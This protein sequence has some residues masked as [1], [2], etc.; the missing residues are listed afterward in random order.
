MVI[1]YQN[2]CLTYPGIVGVAGYGTEPPP[3]PTGSAL[4][5]SNN[6]LISASFN[7]T[8]TQSAD[9]KIINVDT[10]QYNY[11]VI[12]FQEYAEYRMGP[13][14]WCINPHNWSAAQYS[15]VGNYKGVRFGNN[16]IISNTNV[17][18]ASIDNNILRYYNQL[19]N[20]TAAYFKLITDQSANNASAF[21]NDTY[22][23]YGSVNSVTGVTTIDVTCEKAITPNRGISANN[24]KVAGFSDL[25]DAVNWTAYKV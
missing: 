20:Y 16:F 25:N 15:A 1:Q 9:S 18:T 23:G 14:K 10:T 6:G 11:Q 4:Y 2:R 24:F 17:K 19:P 8:F 22:L 12:T 21:W 13:R 5:Y 7:G 3:V